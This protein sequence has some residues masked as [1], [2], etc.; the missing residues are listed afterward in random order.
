[1]EDGR[2]LVALMESACA[3]ADADRT[4]A[5]REQVDPAPA[6]VLVTG[7]SGFLGSALLARLRADDQGTI[8]VM[9]RRP[10]AH[11]ESLHNVDVVY[12]DLGDPAAVDRAV[13]GVDI[14]YHLGAAMKARGWA[15]FQAATVLGT[16]NVVESCLRHHVRKLVYVSSMTV[17]DYASHRAGDAVTETAALE[18]RP[19]ERGFYTQAKLQAEQIVL[20][21]ARDRGLPAVLLRPGQIFGR[22][23]ETVPPYGTLAIAGRWLVVGSG[24]LR[25]PL[26][27]VD[28]VVDGLIAGGARPTANGSIYHLVDREPFTQNQYIDM[29]RTGAL[30]GLR[31]VRAPRALLYAAGIAMEL[32]GR[33]LHRPMPLS[34]YRV[35]SIT[36]LTFDCSKAERDL[37]WRPAV[38]SREGLAR[39]YPAGK[40]FTSP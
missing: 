26:V 34:R 20:N 11:L 27:Y 30:Q 7:G 4:G 21:A 25:L 29:C 3:R 5:F 24:G 35:R 37:A 9:A 2:R 28:D 17:L 12:G 33:L 14:V 8:R 10:S 22:G 38:G 1:M 32:L 6:R 23:A 13:A 36:E 40:S 19:E 15:D 39:T 18:P 31:V 16:A